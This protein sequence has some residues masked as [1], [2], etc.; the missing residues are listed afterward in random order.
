M[1]RLKA[2]ILKLF[3]LIVVLGISVEI[4]SETVVVNSINYEVDTNS[5]Y[6][7]VLPGDYSTSRIT[8]PANITYNDKQYK[9]CY[10][11]NNA[12]K[13]CNK[14][15]NITLPSTLKDIGD[16]AFANCTSLRNINLPSK[17]SAIGR[18]A[19]INNSNLSEIQFPTDTAYS[20]GMSAFRNCVA[21]ESVKLEKAIFSLSWS[22]FANCTNLNSVEMTY[23]KGS[24]LS[25]SIFFNCEKLDNFVI[26]S[27]PRSDMFNILTEASYSVGKYTFGNCKNLRVITFPGNASILIDEYSFDHCSSLSEIDFKA[28]Q[29]TFQD[30]AFNGCTKLKKI[31]FSSKN[32]IPSSSGNAFD[33]IHYD[34]TELEVSSYMYDWMKSVRSLGEAYTK[35]FEWFKFANVTNGDEVNSINETRIRNKA[36]SVYDFNGKQK[37]TLTKGINIIK[38]QDGKSKKIMVK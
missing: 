19:F 33:Q 29:I 22:A 20:I 3:L 4:H 36:Y 32:L 21:L 25:D 1:N 35:Q 37:A 18:A 2:S 31:A 16:S 28:N 27:E 15:R 5:E 7:V 11:S 17:L 38:Y 13:N 8:I 26:P 34:N 6:A 24:E 10:I 30:H 14:L 12:F 23:V 9:V